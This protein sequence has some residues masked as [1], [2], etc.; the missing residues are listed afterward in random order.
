[1]P[2]ISA[3]WYRNV[4]ELV[5][6]SSEWIRV[7][8]E[9]AA[10]AVLLVFAGMFVATWW[11]AWTRP[12]LPVARALPA[13]AMTVPACLLSRVT[14]TCGRWSVPAARS[15]TSP[16][17]R[18]V[19]NTV[20]GRAR[21]QSQ[22]HGQERASAGAQ[23]GWRCSLRRR[24]YSSECII[25]TDVVAGLVLGALLALSVPA[26]ARVLTPVVADARAHATA[27][28]LVG[29]AAPETEAGHARTVRRRWADRSSGRHRV[30]PRRRTADRWADQPRTR[31]TR[32]PRLRDVERR[33]RRASTSTWSRAPRRST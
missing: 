12:P 13:P 28:W 20:T 5:A 18:H 30:A 2:D 25:R 1:V 16:R 32:A 33:D 17:S 4:V 27:V 7:L 19:P 29:S 22:S 9:F 14:R 23:S 31:G 15:P 8:A 24:A 10:E 11:R 26:L 3:E 6:G 21:Q